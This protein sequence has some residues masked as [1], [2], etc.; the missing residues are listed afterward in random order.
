VDQFANLE[1]EIVKVII[2][3]KLNLSKNTAS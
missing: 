2:T 1:K 3:M